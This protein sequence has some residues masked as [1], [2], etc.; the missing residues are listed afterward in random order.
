[1]V[2]NTVT[3]AGRACGHLMLFQVPVQVTAVAQLL[4]RAEAVVVDLEQVQ[5][6]YHP[7]VLQ[8]L[9]DLVLPH[10]IMV[11]GAQRQCANVN[12]SIHTFQSHN[13]R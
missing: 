4:H 1:M 11:T 5:Q 13:A 2:N 3:C 8:L 12:M 9:V 6:L 10:L 7:R